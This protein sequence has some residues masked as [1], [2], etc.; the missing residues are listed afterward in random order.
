MG[1]A[2][3][4]VTMPRDDRANSPANQV[5]NPPVLAQSNTAQGYQKKRKREKA[6]QQTRVRDI[7]AP[8]DSLAVTPL[9]NPQ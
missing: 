4:C 3:S 2:S 6:K 8:N 9:S 1:A 5:T 7:L